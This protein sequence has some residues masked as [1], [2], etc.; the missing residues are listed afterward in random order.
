MKK[1]FAEIIF[2]HIAVVSVLVLA[3]LAVLDDINPHMG[4]LRRSFALPVSIAA[5][6]S[7]LLLG[8][9]GIS[10]FVTDGGGKDKER[11]PAGKA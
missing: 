6:M 5:G 4:F 8:V 2:A 7:A 11:G 1:R 3:T 10:R 9:F